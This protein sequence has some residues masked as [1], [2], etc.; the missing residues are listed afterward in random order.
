MLGLLRD[1]AGAVLEDVRR[2]AGE[3]LTRIGAY[4]DPT[5]EFPGEDDA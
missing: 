1:V 5:P 3:L 2:N 4:L